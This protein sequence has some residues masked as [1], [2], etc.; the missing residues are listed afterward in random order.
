[1][2]Q[3]QHN[4]CTL[5]TTHYYAAADVFAVCTCR[6]TGSPRR[7]RSCLDERGSARRESAVFPLSVPVLTYPRRDPGPKRPRAARPRFPHL[8]EA[9][10]VDIQQRRRQQ[11]Q[12]ST[13][14]IGCITVYIA[15]LPSLVL[16]VH[17]SARTDTYLVSNDMY[18][19][20]YY[21]YWCICCVHILLA[22]RRSPAVARPPPLL[23]VVHSSTQQYLFV[24]T[25]VTVPSQA[26]T[27]E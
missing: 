25:L 15:R 21:R 10:K 22:R 24:C 13:R 20:Y 6:S 26:V 4:S 17:S 3:Q 16:V 27:R 1:M 8:S 11:Q 23:M 14:Y 9:I 18:L 2:Q 7:C 5:Y 12:S 19:V